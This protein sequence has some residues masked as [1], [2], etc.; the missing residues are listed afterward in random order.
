MSKEFNQSKSQKKDTYY[1]MMQ[2]A[3]LV[4][5]VYITDRNSNY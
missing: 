1:Y 5:R 4:Y 3:V 2:N